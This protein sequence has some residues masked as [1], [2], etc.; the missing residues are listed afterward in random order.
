MLRRRDRA[1]TILGQFIFSNVIREGL[2]DILLGTAQL[3][4]ALR[5][6]SP[7]HNP[8]GAFR[9][10]SHFMKGACKRA[11]VERFGLHAIRHLHASILFNEG[12]ELSVV[13]RQ[14]RHTKPKAWK[15]HSSALEHTGRM[16]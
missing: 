6:S 11:G 13:Q 14:L 8:G 7:N 10:R 4:E 2:K 3:Y 15:T 1:V 9:E 5:E 12:T 16:Y